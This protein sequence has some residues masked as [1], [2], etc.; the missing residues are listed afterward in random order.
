MIRWLTQDDSSPPVKLAGTPRLDTIR[1][2]TVSC[3]HSFAVRLVHYP[4]IRQ[5]N[6]LIYW[7]KSFDLS[8]GRLVT[9]VISTTI[10]VHS[11]SERSIASVRTYLVL[12]RTPKLVV[13]AFFMLESSTIVH[14]FMDCI[15]EGIFFRKEL[16]YPPQLAEAWSNHISESKMLCLSTLISQRAPK[17]SSF[18]AK[19]RL[20]LI[21][22]LFQR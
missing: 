18:G 16:S 17:S 8:K 10:W 21:L 19:V 11:F 2:L 22:F 14:F 20:R 1:W 7:G 15:Q 12:D 5:L 6:E 13:Y 4:R 3:W 9:F